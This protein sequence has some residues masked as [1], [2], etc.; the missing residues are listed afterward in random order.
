MLNKGSLAALRNRLRR[1]V[2]PDYAY[3]PIRFELSML[4]L[5]LRAARVRA[6]YRDQ[7]DLLVNVGCG[8]RGRE[9]FVNVD[10]MAAP[11]VSCVYDCRAS[12][13]FAD[14]SVRGL[15]SEHF[16]EH[17]HYEEEVPAFLAE[18]R[19]VL[20]PQ[21]VLRLIVP[22]GGQYLRAYSA[23]GW[24]GVSALRGLS[25]EHVDPWLGEHYQTPMELINA[26]FRQGVEHKFA[27]DAE[28]LVRLL[29]RSGF[30]A[31][32][33]SFGQSALPELAIDSSDRASES[34]YVEALRL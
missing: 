18:C 7:R 25:A 27:Y 23:G 14:Q 13:P 3:H 16:F 4:G 11:G 30:R 9:G 29:E 15:F 1:S 8:A 22:D 17:L 33:S 34:L 24:N 32:Q 19:R 10:G 31:H 21:G 12:L 28:T 20:A 5:R 2:L 6:R 26:V